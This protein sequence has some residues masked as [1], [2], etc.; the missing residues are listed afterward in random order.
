MV[1]QLAREFG[2]YVGT[3]ARPTVRRRSDFRRA[4]VRRLENDVLKTS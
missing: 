3:D 4:G 1:T 2:A